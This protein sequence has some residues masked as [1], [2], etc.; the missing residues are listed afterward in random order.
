MHA[1]G[2]LHSVH[3][4]IV[5]NVVRGA[6][7][8][9]G[10][11]LLAV[12]QAPVLSGGGDVRIYRLRRKIRDLQ[13]SVGVSPTWTLGRLKS[14]FI[15]FLVAIEFVRYFLI[16]YLAIDVIATSRQ[17]AEVAAA[18]LVRFEP[19]LPSLGIGTGWLFTVRV[20]FER[21]LSLATA[22]TAESPSLEDSV[23]VLRTAAD[24]IEVLCGALG[25]RDG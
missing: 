11:F 14:T 17:Y 1:V 21:D 22:A 18:F 15:I 25:A 5:R 20:V 6:V 9:K 2:H 23:K 8:V 19:P 3:E 10:S 24:V 12:L 4:V 16:P 7:K 13:V